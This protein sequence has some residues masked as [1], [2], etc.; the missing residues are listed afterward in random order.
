VV[1]RE[2][3]YRGD[4]PQPKVEGRTVILVDDGL[5]TGATMLA[6]IKALRQQH[7]AQI[8]VA[9]P[10]ASPQT[11]EEIDLNGRLSS[12]APQ[13]PE[14]RGFATWTQETSDQ[15]WLMP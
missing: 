3:V 4:R 12:D 7:P 13:K 2:R 14:Q 10:T 9:V 6:A 15:L 11:C 1:R 5:A 8:V